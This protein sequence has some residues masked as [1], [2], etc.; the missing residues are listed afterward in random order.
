[1]KI[2]GLILY[3][4]FHRNGVAVFQSVY[5]HLFL[6]AVVPPS[7][8][9]IGRG[10]VPIQSIWKRIYRLPEANEKILLKKRYAEEMVMWSNNTFYLIMPRSIA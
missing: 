1:V 5:Y 3:F 2:I 7:S 9:D 8:S 6:H 10:E 4:S